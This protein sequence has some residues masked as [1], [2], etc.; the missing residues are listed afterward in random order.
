MMDSHKLYQAID[1]CQPTD[2]LHASEL[3]GLGDQLVQDA[4]LQ[5]TRDRSVTFDQSLG[6][7]FRDVSPPADLEARLLAAVLGASADN[8]TVNPEPQVS[9]PEREQPTVDPQK[10]RRALL[11]VL[12][13]G[14]AAAALLVVGWAFTPQTITGEQ[15]V[16][17]T[18]DQQWVSLPEDSAEAWRSDAPP[19][20]HPADTTNLRARPR[21]WQTIDTDLDS[22]AVVYDLRTHRTEPT[23]YLFAL[24][25]GSL[26]ETMNAA[27]PLKPQ[28]NRTG[29][30]AVS[31]W[32][33]KDVVYVLVVDGGEK[34]YKNIVIPP[35]ISST[36][37]PAAVAAG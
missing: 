24:Q 14:V 27:P 32:R 5:T 13:A 4:S 7:T 22:H 11:Y 19:E 2:D 30:F 25:C 6:K 10:S 8:P 31:T 37:S 26:V 15:L 29:R 34:R 18:L 17:Q 3:G 23:A 12:G 20:S 36:P 16:A 28:N 1:A 35:Q 9:L 21:A 33:V